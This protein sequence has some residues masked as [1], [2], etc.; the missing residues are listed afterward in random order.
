MK[1]IKYLILGVMVYLIFLVVLMPASVVLRFVTLPPQVK[2]NGVDGSIWH[3]SIDTVQA[4]GRQAEQV[5]W[6]I[7]P[8]SLL[9]GALNLDVNVGNRNSAIYGKTNLTLTPSTVKVMDLMLQTDSQTVIGKAR[10]PFRS[11]VAGEINLS[12][13][14]FAY[15]QP[16]CERLSGH[17][18]LH[19]LEV[20]NQFGDFPFG[21]F[22]LG[23]DCDQGDVIV[24]TTEK[25][26][27]IGVSGRLWLKA[28][29][30]VQLQAKIKPT[31]NMPANVRDNLNFLGQPDAQGA[32][33]LTYSGRVPGL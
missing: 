3:G 4:Y 28:N 29:A 13:S 17:L 30:Q 10:L 31:N 26:N 14:E 8:L 11:E 16:W 19:N 1:R 24:T 2:I 32:Y 21:S 23:M 27:Q 9:T 20:N 5:E 22:R 25:D 18:Q 6:Q 7:H 33:P 15:G 12:V